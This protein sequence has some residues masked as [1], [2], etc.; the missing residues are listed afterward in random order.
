MKVADITGDRIENRKIKVQEGYILI[1][2]MQTFLFE[3]ILESFCQK[4]NSTDPETQ[5]IIFLW[6]IATNAVP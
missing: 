4:E 2:E 5:H 1:V 6:R 3:N